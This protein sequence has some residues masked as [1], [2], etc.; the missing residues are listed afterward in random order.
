M[1]HCK[2]IPDRV[3]AG[4]AGWDQAWQFEV[5]TLVVLEEQGD[6]GQAEG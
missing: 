1:N 3:V 6:K 2:L 5:L 4:Y